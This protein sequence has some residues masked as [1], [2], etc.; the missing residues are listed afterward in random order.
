MEPNWF[1]WVIA[2]L[3]ATMLAGVFL[4]AAQLVLT[5]RHF[6]FLR[7]AAGDWQRFFQLFRV[8]PPVPFERCSRPR[9]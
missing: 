7:R 4:W 8:A 9:V 1:G 6:V 5:V 3:G 2:I